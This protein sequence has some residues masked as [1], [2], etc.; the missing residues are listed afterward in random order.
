VT[1]N[2]FETLAAA[3]KQAADAFMQ[4]SKICLEGA[5]RLSSLNLAA[6]REVMEDSAAVAGSLTDIKSM[7]DFQSIHPDVAPMV[8][9]AVAYTR[10]VQEIATRTQDEL[11]KL[12][13]VQFAQFDL[14]PKAPAAWNAALEMFTKGAQQMAPA[15][16]KAAAKSAKK[17]A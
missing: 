9:K 16:V 3:N 6:M 12:M 7:Q 14:D 2:S 4:M 10:N 1:I 8:E 13:N 15:P 5:E 17:A 11:S